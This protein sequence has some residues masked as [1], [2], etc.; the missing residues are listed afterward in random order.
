MR[1]AAFAISVETYIGFDSAWTSGNKGAICSVTFKGPTPPEV[2]LP[3]MVSFDE[4]VCFIRERHQGGITLI[5]LD[6]PTVVPNQTGMRPVDRVAGYLLGWLGGAAQPA[7]RSRIGMFDDGSPIWRF[8]AQLDAKEHPEEARTAVTGL[9]L[10][11]VFPALSLAALDQAFFGRLRQPKY[12]PDR[13]TFSIDAWRRVSSTTAQE[14][15]RFGCHQL[16]EFCHG[17]GSKPRPRKADQD[18]LDSVLCVLIAM[19]WRMRPRS[20]SVLL[21][22]LTAGY[23][24]VPATTLVRERL[25]AGARRLSVKVDGLLLRQPWHPPSKPHRGT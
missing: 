7:N 6:Q 24:V 2:Q 10:V 20:Y 9:Y 23:M 12:N 15:G 25:S 18:M 16:T 19:R 13:R 21:G 1:Q 11:E 14:L 4:A 3:K 22:D 8:V 5:A 17:L